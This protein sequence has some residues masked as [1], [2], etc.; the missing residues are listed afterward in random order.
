VLKKYGVNLA[1]VKDTTWNPLYDYQ[2][3]GT[4]GSSTFTF[5]QVPIGQSG[6]TLSDTNMRLAGQLSSGEAFLIT[7]LQVE[8]YPAVEDLAGTSL[9]PQASEDFY[10]V[11]TADAVLQ[12]NIL[13]KDYVTQGPLLKFLPEQHFELD[14]SVATTN[15]S[16]DAS[17]SMMQVTGKPYEIIPLT[18]ISSQSFD[19]TITFKTAV[20][21][22]AAAKLGVSL[23][24]YSIRNA[25]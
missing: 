10:K 6:K 16:T 20:A 21:I 9:T 25:Q 11:M 5:F 18:L 23:R 8:F 2:E 12:L 3:Y 19:V 14:S 17:I 15:T 24:G 4:S 13:N 1:N 22:N 7:G